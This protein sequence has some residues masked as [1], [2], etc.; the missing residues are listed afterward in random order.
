M[1]ANFSRTFSTWE[2]PGGGFGMNE[3]VN[4]TSGFV[5][6]GVWVVGGNHASFTLLIVNFG[7]AAAAAPSER[8][9]GLF[10]VIEA[11]DNQ[12]LVQSTM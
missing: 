4:W 2:A 9:F 3:R 11:A 10:L 12:G 6:C 8:G 7:E 5:L 1:L